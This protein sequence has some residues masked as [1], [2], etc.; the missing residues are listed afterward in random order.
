MPIDYAALKT[1]LATDPAS[2]GYATPL[3]AQEWPACAALI[4]APGSAT[5]TLPSMDN[6][7]FVTAFLPYLATA[8]GLPS[9]KGQFYGVLWQT[10]LSMPTISFNNS[11]LIPKIN[12]FKS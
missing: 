5:V 8:L 3:A 10:I 11:Y 4:N 1:E 9:P 12:Y 6:Q 7:S 2:L